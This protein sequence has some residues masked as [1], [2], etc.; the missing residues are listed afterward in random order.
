MGKVIIA[1]TMFT[2]TAEIT[3]AQ[4][5]EFGIKGGLNAS[6]FSNENV[7]DH[8]YKPSFNLGVLAHIHVN[9]SFAIQPELVYSGQGTKYSNAPSD[10]R[11]SLGYINLPVLAQLMTAN[12]FRFETGPQIGALV[13]A[14]QVSGGTSVDVKDSYK[15]TDF[16]WAF[17]VGYI[18]PSKFGIDVRYNA[19]VSGI[20]KNISGVRNSVFQAGVFY[21]FK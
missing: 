16:S 21:Q 3:N 12:G 15:T 8:K 17:G 14:K 10:Y 18:F 9:K 11:I 2:A 1:L 6:T 5:V 20:I 13:S 19:G 7:Y 4:H